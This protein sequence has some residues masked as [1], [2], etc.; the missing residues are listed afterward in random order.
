MLPTGWKEATSLVPAGR[1]EKT[2][3]NVRVR[4][5]YRQGLSM[6]ALAK[7]FRVSVQRIYQIVHAKEKL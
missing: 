3:R 1:P 7:R 5:L 4:D 2:Q 6:P